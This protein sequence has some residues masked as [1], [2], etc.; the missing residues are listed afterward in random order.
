MPSAR[1]YDSIV[2]ISNASWDPVDD[3]GGMEMVK[4]WRE[5]VWRNAERLLAAKTDAE[6]QQVTDSIETNAVAWERLM[7]APQV[8]P[9]TARSGTPT[10]RPA[11]RR[12]ARLRLRCRDDLDPQAVLF[13]I[14]GTLIS[15][16]G[17]GARSWRYAFQELHGIPAD[18]GSSPTPA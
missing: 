2:T 10:A 16:G 5:G 3:I 12:Q 9:A 1:R 14:D 17:A 4:G 15:T 11:A 13:D 6:R 7:A 18:I 8:R